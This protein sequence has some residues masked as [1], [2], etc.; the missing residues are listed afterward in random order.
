MNINL[1]C[2][3]FLGCALLLFGCGG[4]ANGA[5]GGL[6]GTI[7]YQDIEDGSVYKMSL[8]DAKMTRLFAGF[9]PTRTPDGTFIYEANGD[10]VESPDGIQL[11]T[12]IKGNFD[13]TPRYDDSFSFPALSPDGT[14]IA[15]NTL[16]NLVY[17]C[18]RDNGQ[19]VSHFTESPP[20]AGLVGWERPSWT[21]DNRIV[22]AGNLGTPGLYISDAGWTT[23]TRFDPGINQPFDAKVSPKGGVVAFEENNDIYTLN[24]DGSGLKQLTSTNDEEKMPTWSPDGSSVA[25]FSG[26]DLVTVHADG[27]SPKTLSMGDPNVF[28]NF[29]TDQAFDWTK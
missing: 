21:P 7:Y 29:N 15:Y 20:G 12:I 26:L 1:R 19:I 10:L 27:S 8:S 4:G 24:L 23:L 11:R 18:R 17:I 16:T 13:A 9:Y 6:D 25:A 22:V 28:F 3:T 5:G 2:S 14:L